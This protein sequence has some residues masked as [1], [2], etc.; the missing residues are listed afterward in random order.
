MDTQP[1]S[2]S[3][4]LPPVPAI[5]VSWVQIAPVLRAHR[6]GEPPPAI[7]LDLGFT[8]DAAPLAET[9][10]GI[11]FPSGA[12]LTWKALAEIAETDNACFA[13]EGAGDRTAVRKVGGFSEEARR[14]VALYPTRRAPTMLIAG[15]PMHRLRDAD[16]IADTE[17]K[18][19]AAAPTGTVLE[20]C[21]GL[22]YTTALAA[23]TAQHVLA[24]EI[25]PFVAETAAQNPWSRAAFEHPRIERRIGDMLDAVYE[26]DDR[27]FTT[28][29]HDP[30][31]MNLAG[32]LYS[33]AFYGELFRITAPR[34]R[35]YHHIGD[36][37]SPAGER[38]VRGV[39]RRLGEAG[40]VRVAKRADAFGV[41]A[42]RP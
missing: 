19:K 18:M 38:T 1:R 27:A 26:L 35:L 42:F 37:S 30:P 7:S 23:R 15:A 2:A 3:P 24:F 5:L 39:M 20:T 12:R 4:A 31:P 8:R 14:Y 25:D 28:I 29:V 32:D 11:A 10:D 33:G 21:M 22:G 40:F 17:A 41:V 6:H 36:L 34:G 9:D 16:P 13:I